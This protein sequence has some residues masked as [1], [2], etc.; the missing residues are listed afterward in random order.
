MRR[1]LIVE[2][3]QDMQ[4]MYRVIFRKCPDI[5]IVAQVTTA[6]EALSILPDMRPDL[7]IVDISLPGMDGIMLISEIRTIYPDLKILVATGHDPDR[8]LGAATRAG[9]D[10]FLQKG[11]VGEIR[12]KVYQLLG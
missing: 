9:A 1:L 7:I 8:Y 3:H 2:D 11:D 4:V 10:G 6:E 12:E 5:E